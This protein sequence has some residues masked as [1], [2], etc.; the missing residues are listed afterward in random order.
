MLHASKLASRPVLM[1]LATDSLK[2]KS[3]HQCGE[4]TTCLIN[5]TLPIYIPIKSLKTLKALLIIINYMHSSYQ[6]LISQIL[7]NLSS[8]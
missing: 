2:L 4:V 1:F 3:I 8:Y 5:F 7:T 6:I